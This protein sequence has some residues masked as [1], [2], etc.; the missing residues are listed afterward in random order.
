MSS[1][2]SITN[3]DVKVPGEELEQHIPSG[4][5]DLKKDYSK[6]LKYWIVDNNKV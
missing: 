3:Q 4:Q 1:S 2:F 6:R 5:M